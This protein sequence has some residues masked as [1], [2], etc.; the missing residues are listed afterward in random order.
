MNKS[1]LVV[2]LTLALG[3]A[4]VR[5]E[6]QVADVSIGVG[7]VNVSGGYES[8]SFTV[9]SPALDARA[10]VRVSERF[11]IE[12]FVTYGR[13]SIPA[14]AWAPY[15]VGADTQRTEG[16]YGVVVHQRLRSLSR[17]GFHAHLSYGLNGTYFKESAPER[18][19]VYGPRNISTQPAWTRN[20]TDP[21]L[22]PSVGFGIRKSLGDHFAVR[23]DGDL[24]TF[25]GA[26][27]GGRASIG[28]VVPFGANK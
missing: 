6:A 13:R 4:A 11:S 23:A 26:P 18:Q 15:A 22:L 8:W 1:K 9:H 5:A 28:I 27:I 25:F 12:P 17:P 24:V 14:N 16:M 7:G 21:M 20:Q 19:F 2:V 10:N 3:G